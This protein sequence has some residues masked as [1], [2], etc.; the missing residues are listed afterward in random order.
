MTGDT[1]YKEANLINE[2]ASSEIE[3]CFKK[4]QSLYRT[5]QN[6][7]ELN[8]SFVDWQ[9]YIDDV[10]T[11]FDKWTAGAFSA[12]AIGEMMGLATGFDEYLAVYKMAKPE[13]KYSKASLLKMQEMVKTD[14]EKE[15][16]DY[17]LHRPKRRK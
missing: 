17:I 7:R 15:Q 4:E 11:K 9:F 12:V 10:K 1:E 5:L 8:P 16:L 14:Q 6:L 2:V 3:K 13:S